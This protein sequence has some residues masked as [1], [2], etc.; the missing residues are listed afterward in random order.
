MSEKELKDISLPVVSASTEQKEVHTPPTINPQH[1]HEKDLVM[2]TAPRPAAL[3]PLALP[4]PPCP[5]KTPARPRRTPLAERAGWRRRRRC[6]T[7][8]R[9]RGT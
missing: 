1:T 5:T 7:G 8:G 3:T 6:V 4:A 2:H 9:T